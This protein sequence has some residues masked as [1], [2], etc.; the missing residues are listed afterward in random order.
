MSSLTT[1]P[2]KGTHRCLGC[3]RWDSWQ[4]G[5]RWGEAR[6]PEKPWAQGWGRSSLHL[7]P[8]HYSPGP[9]P[10][11]GAEAGEGVQASLTAH[12]Q[13]GSLAGWDVVGHVALPHE[14]ADP[15]LLRGLLGPPQAGEAHGGGC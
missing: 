5:V 6:S 11:L 13:R 3:C 9:S 15:Q 4:G 12:R 7:F 10:R 1:A 8:A 2:P 14:G